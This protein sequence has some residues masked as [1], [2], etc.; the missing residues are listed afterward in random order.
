MKGSLDYLAF[1][2]LVW[3]AFHVTETMAFLDRVIR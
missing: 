2:L 1:L 3:M